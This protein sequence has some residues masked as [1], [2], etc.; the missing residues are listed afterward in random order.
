LEAVAGSVY[1][2][3]TFNVQDG[4]EREP[5]PPQLLKRTAGVTM[6]AVISVIAVDSAA[7]RCSLEVVR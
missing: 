6:N 4:H 1:F 5:Q 3:L 7:S 2:R